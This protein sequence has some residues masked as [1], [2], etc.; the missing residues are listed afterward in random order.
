MHENESC[1]DAM[2]AA[3]CAHDVDRLLA[4]FAP[5]ARYEDVTLART[6]AG[7]AELRSYMEVLFAV[8]PDL[9][10][11]AD[12]RFAT[13]SQGAAHW[14]MEATRS[15]EAIPGTPAKRLRIEGVDLY[16]FRGGKVTSVKHVWD[17]RQ[18]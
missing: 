5:D 7:H 3:W 14:V 6:H 9:H 4:C 2:F 12:V 17:Y 13:P 8:L 16:E 10:L 11:R 15:A 1:I 18:W